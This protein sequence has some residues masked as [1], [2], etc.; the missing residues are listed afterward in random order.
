MNLATTRHGTTNR[1]MIPSGR[2]ALTRRRRARRV[3]GA[4]VSDRPSVR[5][6]CGSRGRSFLAQ[7][8]PI[9]LGIVPGGDETSALPPISLAGASGRARQKSSATNE[10]PR[11]DVI[12][13]A[14][15]EAR[16][17]T[18]IVSKG[19]PQRVMNRNRIARATKLGAAIPHARLTALR[20]SCDAASSAC[21]IGWERGEAPARNSQIITQ[22]G[23]G[24]T[25]FDWWAGT[26]SD[27]CLD[28]PVGLPCASTVRSPR[29][30]CENRLNYFAL[31]RKVAAGPNTNQQRIIG[32]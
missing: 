11:P 29:I 16:G 25:T 3:R 31:L 23:V 18:E 4:T 22:M 8:A 15:H 1:A 7:Q 19:R 28:W 24:M 2:G 27:T 12:S 14:D 6:A 30:G 32:S 13:E 17:I 26:R 21:N 9:G 5:L 10:M 20:Q